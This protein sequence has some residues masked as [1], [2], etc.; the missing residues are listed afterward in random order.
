MVDDL[1]AIK[2]VLDS[3]FERYEKIINANVPYQPLALKTFVP[4]VMKSS[5]LRELIKGTLYPE[6]VWLAEF[7]YGATVLKPEDNPLEKLRASGKAGTFLKEGEPIYKEL[8]EAFLNVTQHFLKEDVN[9]TLNLFAD[10]VYTLRAGPM[11]RWA[12][13][14]EL[15]RSLEENFREEA[16][17]LFGTNEFIHAE[18]VAVTG[19]KDLPPT[20][21]PRKPWPKETP[22]WR[23]M[24]VD[25]SKFQDGDYFVAAP[26]MIGM[27]GNESLGAGDV[28]CYVFRKVGGKWRVV[29]M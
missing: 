21:D 29:G 22:W 10:Q 5:T 19:V 26:S 8:K 14:E 6:K 15:K 24:A 13:K 9:E 11:A 23:G 27:I 4:L 12:K 20:P 18:L 28:E 7:Q 2:G 16:Y 17:S 3:Y 25:W 1:E